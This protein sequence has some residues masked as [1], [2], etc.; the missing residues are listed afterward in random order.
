MEHVFPGLDVH[1]AVAAAVARRKRVISTAG[2]PHQPR[3]P[4]RATTT[5]DDPA[6]AACP[7]P[8]PLTVPARPRARTSP[9]HQLSNARRHMCARPYSRQ[10]VCVCRARVRACGVY[11]GGGGKVRAHGRVGYK[12]TRAP[13]GSTLRLKTAPATRHAQQCGTPGQPAGT[14][15]STPVQHP[16]TGSD[17]AVRPGQ[18]HMQPASDAR[19]DIP[20]APQ[21][22]GRGAVTSGSS[23]K[24]R[25]AARRLY[26]QRR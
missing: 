7:R 11:V 1:M 21:Q 15:P 18:V 8:P 9:V 19:Y 2:A 14:A 4:R 3:R 26:A 16:A 17:G 12:T 13:V 24:W 6:R 22:R 23:G 10:R 5:A 20:Q 25:V